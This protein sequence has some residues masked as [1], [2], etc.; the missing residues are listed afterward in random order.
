MA[1]Q[2]GAYASGTGWQSIV[3]AAGAG[4]RMNLQRR[5]ATSGTQAS[6]NA[7]FLKNPCSSGV[8]GALNPQGAS[9]TAS[10]L[11]VENSGSG[12]VKT[13]LTT[14]SNATNSSNFAI[15]VLSLENDWRLETVGGGSDGYRF[16]KVDGV[17][18]EAGDTSNAR[19]TSASGDYR[20]VM[21]LVNFVRN[22]NAGVKTPFEAA[23]VG[24]ITTAL[25]NPVAASC[26]TLPRGLAL[27]PGI[28][29]VCTVGTQVM[30]G[31]VSGNNC[32]PQRLT[33]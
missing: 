18:P 20:F 12:N 30:K 3:G 28:T 9:T 21:E 22:D 25:A 23:I 4:K 17:H 27:V 15:G 10:L 13:G 11:V 6:S 8:G 26:A 5:V 7:F 19:L 29:N 31:T 14:A 2:G 33:F 16:I 1:S 24:Q 32:A